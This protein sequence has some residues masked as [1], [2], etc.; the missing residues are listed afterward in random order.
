VATGR[1]IEPSGLLLI[2]IPVSLASKA[3]V[4]ELRDYSNPLARA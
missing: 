3:I 1:L 4:F 2:E